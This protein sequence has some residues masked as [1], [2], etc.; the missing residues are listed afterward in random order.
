MKIDSAI[1]RL[2]NRI[3]NLNK[4]R[5]QFE[6]VKYIATTIDENFDTDMVYID[7]LGEYISVVIS[8]NNK[9]DFAKHLRGFAKNGYRRYNNYNFNKSIIYVLKNKK[10]STHIEL[11]FFIGS[12]S[13]CQFVQVGTQ[14]VPKFE[15][16]CE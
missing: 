1:K 11:E 5:F 6:E 10:Y 8:L 7:S 3:K 12:S 15:L 9:D 13:S 2:K 4:M 16:Q 14:E